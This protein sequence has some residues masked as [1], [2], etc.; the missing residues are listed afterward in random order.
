MVGLT[1]LPT[2]SYKELSAAIVYLVIIHFQCQ[3]TSMICSFS[4]FDSCCWYKGGQKWNMTYRCICC[5][6]QCSLG[7]HY[8]KCPQNLVL[9]MP[10]ELLFPFSASFISTFIYKYFIIIVANVFGFLIS[11]SCILLVFVVHLIA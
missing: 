11:D 6:R 9:S 4:E 3:I 2:Y 5:L 8:V 1:F 7:F 10:H